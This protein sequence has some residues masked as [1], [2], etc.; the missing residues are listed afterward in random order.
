MITKSYSLDNIISVGNYSFYV[1]GAALYFPSMLKALLDSEGKKCLK[2]FTV[3]GV[4]TKTFEEM[5]AFFKDNKGL[6]TVARELTGDYVYLF[7]D[8]FLN[9]DYAK[10]TKSITISGYTFDDNLLALVKSFEKEYITKI[11]T[12]LIYT[13]VRSGSDLTIRN[14]GDGSSPL[15][16]DNYSTEVL[17]EV[18][19]VMN[20][21]KKSPPGGRIC[22]LNGE[23]GT[24]K[25]HLIRSML[26]QLDNIFVIIPSNLVDSLDKPEFLPLLL[27]VK[28]EHNKPIIMVIEDGDTC[29]VPRKNDNI[30]TITSLLNLSDGILGAIIDIKMIIST[31][32]DIVD[33]DQAIMRP[34][35][36]CKQIHVGPLPYEQANKVYRRISKNEE[37][38][39]DIVKKYTLAEIY[40]KFN[41]FG[42][43][44]Q[45][46]SVRSSPNSYGANRRS[47]GFQVEKNNNHD[48]TL[49]KK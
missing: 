19:Y 17:E 22:I 25:T 6:L 41:N 2:D 37:L 47:I 40:D 26:S 5:H 39:L 49:N 1:S 18:E 32:A 48:L 28:N 9:V 38:S 24:G 7:K 20:A 46:S 31:N 10:K 36:L 16:K 3:S 13:I 14:L 44:P 35:R 21:F 33:M 11:K 4:L 34:G 15:M 27:S 23:P 12:N 42:N 8:G 45:T 29:L 43:E 30:S